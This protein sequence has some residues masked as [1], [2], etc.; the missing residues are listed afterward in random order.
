MSKLTGADFM[1][2]IWQYNDS[3]ISISYPDNAARN[4]RTVSDSTLGLQWEVHHVAANV[5]HGWEL[6]EAINT[7]MHDWP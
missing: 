5:E 7:S 3:L 4:M 2:C 1:S 6:K